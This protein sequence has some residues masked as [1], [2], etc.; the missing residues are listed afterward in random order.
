MR[1]TAR[2]DEADMSENGI[3]HCRHDDASPDII[4]TLFRL[5]TASSTA[6]HYGQNVSR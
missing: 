2:Q 4:A 3:N 6:S 1:V 5:L